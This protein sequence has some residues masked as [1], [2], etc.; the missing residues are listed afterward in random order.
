MHS[1]SARSPSIV[2][3]LGVK[4][5][6][7]LY[8]TGPSDLQ[9]KAD[10]VR[11]ECKKAVPDL[12]VKIAGFPY[13]PNSEEFPRDFAD[14]MADHIASFV[15]GVPESNVAFDID[16]GLTLHKVALTQRIIQTE[17]LVVS[18][19]HEIRFKNWV[20]HGTERLFV[21]PRNENWSLAFMKF[22]L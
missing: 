13:N 22:A 1:R 21:F 2:A 16:R 7:V 3:S 4:H 9:S 14:S 15:Q 8:T 17:N 12:V 19:Y 18:L 11:V 10:E 6:L 20:E 5:L